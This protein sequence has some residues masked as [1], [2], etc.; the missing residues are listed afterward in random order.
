MGCSHAQDC[1]LFPLLN[2]SLRDWRNHYGANALYLGRLPAGVGSDTARQTPPSR[3]ARGRRSGSSRCRPGSS[4]RYRH[5][6]KASTPGHPHRVRLPPEP[7]RAQQGPG[8]GPD[9]QSGLQV[10][11]D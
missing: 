6:P 8:G 4:T 5:P 3:L 10:P 7:H 9:S 2:A 11:H 1:P